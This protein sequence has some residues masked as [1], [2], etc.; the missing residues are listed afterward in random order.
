MATDMERQTVPN[1]TEG[2]WAGRAGG[3]AR[4][5]Q[6]SRG[7]GKQEGG[8]G[9][10]ERRAA[11]RGGEPAPVERHLAG[12]LLLRAVRVLARLVDV[13]CAALV[14]A[15]Q[16]LDHEIAP[17]VRVLV[18]QEDL[19]HALAC[20]RVGGHTAEPLVHRL[21]VLAEVR[22]K[23]SLEVLWEHWPAGGRALG[24]DDRG[25]ERHGD[26]YILHHTGGKLGGSLVGG[27]GVVVRM[28]D[29]TGNSDWN[30]ATSSCS[31]DCQWSATMTTAYLAS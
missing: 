1:K 11:Y 19:L 27:V 13:V 18:V 28:R 17:A 29:C 31:R 8:G 22:L 7:G 30:P 5:V 16:V 24:G 4:Q 15:Q 9:S 14:E 25:A 3:E 12:D 10:E 26:G 2:R 6:Q 23:L 21:V 20:G